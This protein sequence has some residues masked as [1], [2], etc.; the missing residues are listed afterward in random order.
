ML[1]C[2][3]FQVCSERKE[4]FVCFSRKENV[5]GALTENPPETITLKR[6]YI[7]LEDALNQGSEVLASSW[8]SATHEFTEPP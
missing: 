5:G 3:Y 8:G 6:Q 1:I 2:V 4:I 7:I